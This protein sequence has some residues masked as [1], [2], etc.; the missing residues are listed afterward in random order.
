MVICKS[1]NYIAS[2]VAVQYDDDDNNNNDN[3][4]KNTIDQ[5]WQEINILN[6]RGIDD[7]RL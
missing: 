2:D 7:N 4:N 6:R 1:V 5:G 3:N